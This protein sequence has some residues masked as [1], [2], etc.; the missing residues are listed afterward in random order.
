[1]RG[2]IMFSKK[3]RVLITGCGGMLG[4]AFYNIFKDKCILKAT[5]IDLNESWLEYLDVRDFDGYK[6]QILNFKP[7]IVIHL[8]ALT[9]LEYCEEH[10]NETYMTNTIGTEN[11]VIISNMFNIELVYISTAGIFDGEKDYYD[12]WD[13]SNPINVYGRSKHL[14]EKYV[15]NNITKY[16]VCRAGWMMGGGYGKDKKFIKKII[17]QIMD[18]KKE[19]YV[20]DDKLGTPTYTYNF[21]KNILELLKT[22]YYGVYNM[23]CDGNCSRH[24]VAVEIIKLL[25]K[26]EKIKIHKVNSEYF[27]KEYF[28]NRPRSEKLVNMKLNLRNLNKMGNWRIKL[29]EYIEKSYFEYIER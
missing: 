5:D 18:G 1:M 11:A 26:E 13:S 25:N 20:V 29:K 15:V 16:F 28:V 19:L 6:K 22:N 3:S 10:P 21:A 2:I 14:G 23:V 9:D 4:E 24:D 12:D 7:E 27:S 17:K 8:A